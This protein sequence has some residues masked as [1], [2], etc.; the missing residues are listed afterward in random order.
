MAE[1]TVLIPLDGSPI[2]EHSLAYLPCLTHLGDVTLHLLSVVDQTEE[3]HSLSSAEV[4]ERERHV[5]T[6]Y[7]QETTVEIESL[8]GLRAM[9]EVQ[10]GVPA[11]VIQKRTEELRPD[12]LV[13][14]THGRS[15]ISRWRHGSVAAK[16]LHHAACP[17][18]MVGPKAIKHGEWNRGYAVASF[19]SILVPLDGSD[20]AEQS[21]STA[22]SIS[23]QFGSKLHLVRAVSPRL[24]G[25]PAGGSG[26]VDLTS[27]LEEG[28]AS[29]LARVRDR[30]HSGGDVVTQV[31]SGDA[32]IAL[33]E[34]VSDEKIDLVVMTS[35]GRSGLVR[36]ALGSVTDRLSGNGKAPVLVV[37]SPGR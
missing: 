12:L 2:A 9:V 5:L 25:D 17:I 6:T 36:A 23:Q 22:A 16:L 10:L 8:V 7:L 35:H 30:L 26:G 20:L 18:L 29:Y 32:A 27:D 21:L 15:G 1:F 28:A 34:Y 13:I 31:L 4:I 37:R 14:S 19:R 3:V 33:D 24:A 11:E